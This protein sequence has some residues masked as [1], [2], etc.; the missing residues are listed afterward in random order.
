MGYSRIKQQDHNNTYYTE[1]V[2]DTIADIATLPTSTKEV[3]I[4]SAAICIEDGEVYLLNSNGEW[5]MIP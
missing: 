2:V 5:V 1:F 3:S 4:G